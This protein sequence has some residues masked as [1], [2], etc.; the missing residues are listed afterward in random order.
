ME[1]KLPELSKLPEDILDVKNVVGCK[2]KSDEFLFQSGKITWADSKFEILPSKQKLTSYKLIRIKTK[3]EFLQDSVAGCVIKQLVPFVS[4]S[5]EPRI[6]NMVAELEKE[7]CTLSFSQE[8]I[9][10]R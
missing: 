10:R 1:V 5:R 4:I 9:V 2:I 7:D 6:E 8:N 3:E